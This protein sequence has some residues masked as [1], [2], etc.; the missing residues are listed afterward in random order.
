MIASVLA[1][2][3]GS[4]MGCNCCLRMYA[5]N[6]ATFYVCASLCPKAHWLAACL[7]SPALNVLAVEQH[8]AARAHV[9]SHE[10]VH[11]EH[12]LGLGGAGEDR[13][14]HV[15]WARAQYNRRR[16]H[17]WRC[18]RRPYAPATQALGPCLAALASDRQTLLSSP[19]AQGRRPRRRRCDYRRC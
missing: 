16:P 19:H 9:H 13:K 15:V 4:P 6:T 12:A 17:V 2:K 11:R 8:L 14:G 7:P 5:V 1:L 18:G 3:S 10:L